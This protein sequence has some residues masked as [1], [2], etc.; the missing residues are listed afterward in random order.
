M[1]LLIAEHDHARY[2]QLLSSTH[3][4]LNITASA[5][6]A[7]LARHAAHCPIWLG[8]PDLLADLLRKAPPPDWIQSTWA[9]ITP[10]LATDL[11]R[12]YRLT[13]AV[14]LFG[15]VMAEYVL[16]HLLAHERRLLALPRAQAERRWD[17]CPGGT[18]Q[19]RTVL[20]V[21][22]GD[23][24]QQVARLLQPFGVIL[25][26]IASQAREQPPFAHVRPLSALADGL[27]QAD[28]LLNLLPD[29]PATRDLYD[30]ALLRRC[31]PSAVFINAGRGASVV[32]ADLCE[33]LTEGR[34]A[35]AV[36]DVCRQEPPPCDHLFWRTPNLLLTGH[37][38]A[39]TSPPAMAQL[40]LQNLHAFQHGQPLQGEVDFERGY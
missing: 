2:S 3:P 27:P 28:Y 30:A 14:G 18:L 7:E 5:D 33:A 36:L 35:A 32:D 39:P 37:T 6:P 20:I 24:G 11:P 12:T 23:I 4:T 21:G 17:T 13:R 38:A 34:L 1:R 25:H 16:G 40:F 26:G 19:G 15:Q 9:G 8:Q 22:I 31:K 10:L 29:T